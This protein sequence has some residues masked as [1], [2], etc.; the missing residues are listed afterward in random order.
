MTSL[1]RVV[2]EEPEQVGAEEV[3]DGG[4]ESADATQSEPTVGVAGNR[5]CGRNVEG[6]ASPVQG[7]PPEPIVNTGGPGENRTPDR[8]IM[9]RLL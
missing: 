2:V 7:D 3:P 8:A 6:I 5:L 1:A 4:A 9:S